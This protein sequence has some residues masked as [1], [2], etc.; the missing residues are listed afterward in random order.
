MK[1]NKNKIFIIIMRNN[2]K[3]IKTK[4]IFKFRYLFLF[5]FILIIIII[6]IFYYIKSNVISKGIK[7][8]RIIFAQS[9]AL[10]GNYARLGISYNLGFIL[11]FQNINRRGGIHNKFLELVTYDDEY[12]PKKTLKNVKLLIEFYD[13]F[14]VVG[15]IGASHSIET[16]N[17]LSPKN[18][19]LLFPLTGTNL[20]R[21]Y[22]DQNILHSR[23]SYFDEIAFIFYYLKKINKKNIGFL[24]QNSPF[25]LSV[26][27]DI[28]FFL[29]NNDKVNYFNIIS[30]SKYEQ[31]DIVINQSLENLLNVKNLYDNNEIK[32]SKIL[33]QMEVILIFSTYE[34]AL[35]IISFLKNI[36]KDLIIFC[37]DFAFEVELE[38]N[39]SKLHKDLTNNIFLMLLVPQ[40]NDN[41]Y[42]RKEILDELKY[43]DTSNDKKNNKIDKIDNYSRTVLLEGY[44]NALLIGEILKNM[45]KNDITRENFKKTIYKKHLFNVKGYQY[46]PYYTQEDCK[47]LNL[48]SLDCPCN[49]GSQKVYLYKY[50]Y[51]SK[52][53]EEFESNT[54]KINCN[55]N[56]INEK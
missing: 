53:F 11:G 33:Q 8:D 9:V 47:K 39:I 30:Y 29:E 14:A 34:R 41:N 25:G 6:G 17:Y 2:N 48:K 37:L 50:S 21:Y 18:I 49:S 40:L 45:D 36:K 13:I 27:N 24:Y 52:K 20:L 32:E 44:L 26:M 19:M 10:S 22:Y 31:N 46:G 5:I 3:I 56:I 38:E 28:N 15:T 55:R 23:S 7:N 43:Y 54:Y 1:K 42:I 4:I 16:I 35:E 51:N 12:D